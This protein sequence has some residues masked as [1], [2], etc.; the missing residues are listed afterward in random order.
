MTATNVL[1]P[2]V[3][4]HGLRATN[5][6]QEAFVRDRLQQYIRQGQEA[7]RGAVERAMQV[8]PHDAVVGTAFT[9]FEAIGPGVRMLFRD[10]TLGLHPNALGQVA[11]R[12]GIPM[13][14]V[15]HLLE[16]EGW[17]AELLARDL[18]EH[19]AH[20]NQRWLVR[21][22]GG[23]ARAVLSDSYRRIDCRPSLA[24]LIEAVRETGAIVTMGHATDLRTVVKVVVPRIH[25][26][27]PGE[28]VVLGATWSNSDF[29]RG[30]NDLSTF[31][32]RPRCWNGATGESVVRNIHLGKRLSDDVEY[33][34]KTL[35]LDS[36]ATAS[37]LRDAARSTLAGGRAQR[38]LEG[39]KTAAETRVDPKGRAEV[40]AKDFSK[41]VAK[42][43]VEA[44]SGG[45]IEQMPAG[46]NL[47]RWSNA[48]SFVAGQLGD[49]KEELKIDLE[50]A[51][52]KVL[53]PALPKEAAA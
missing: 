17:G 4:P 22:I 10:S 29:G 52:G 8:V 42:Q 30:A 34:E 1:V 39:I 11:D 27:Y 47:W 50:R 24:A 15:H 3:I 21:A 7:A 53:A 26:V 25:E 31:V 36:E 9:A 44:F 20:A 32:F 23:Q 40:L 14:Y 12:L 16:K 5:P 28:H 48:I 6:Q 43:V 18:N 13:T 35:R 46:Q 2:E 19:T 51:A 38:Y 49:D 37:A 33:S 45:D 41:D